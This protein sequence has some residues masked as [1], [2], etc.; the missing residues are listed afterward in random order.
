MDNR[1]Q[2]LNTRQKRAARRDEQRRL[3]R[4]NQAIGVLLI[5]LAVLVYRLLRTPSGW[6]FPQGW[7]RLW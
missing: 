7:W 4:R 5:A 3:F 6:I 2:S 1:L